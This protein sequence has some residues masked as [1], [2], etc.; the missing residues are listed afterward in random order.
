[1]GNRGSKSVVRYYSAVVKEQ[2]VNVYR[3]LQYPQLGESTPQTSGVDVCNIF[4][5]YS[6]ELSNK[7]WFLC[8]KIFYDSPLI[9]FNSLNVN[10]R[11]YYATLSNN[12]HKINDLQI[13]P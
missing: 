13:D 6:N 10:T 1:M 2:R 11:R 9:G 5:M 7:L 4:K 8:R 3:Y 12:K